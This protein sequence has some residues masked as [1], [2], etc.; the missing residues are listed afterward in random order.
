M[1]FKGL[2]GRD[3]RE[4][5]RNR[6]APMVEKIGGYEEGLRSLSLEGLREKTAE[7]R[8]R[9][10][11]GTLLDDLLP[12]AFAV[13]REASRRMLGQRHYDVQLIGGAVLHEGRIA[14]MRTGEGKTLAATLP[15][16]LNALSGKGVHV[17]TVNEYLARRDAV[18]MGQIY[19]CLGLTV[20]CITP[21]GSYL[22]DAA[23]TEGQKRQETR[24]N[25]LSRSVGRARDKGRET[26][27][28]QK[29]AG[30]ENITN[31]EDTQPRRSCGS[32][33]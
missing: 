24:P 27:K 32:F 3:P 2:F 13:V 30:K 22:Y 14:E 17:V 28:N 11:E 15:V 12:E 25:D 26:K 7:F 20:G 29:T 23:H 31:T 21:A 10:H 19:D 33:G 16:Y 5:T 6:Y 4:E 18:W 8:T 1:I 9:L